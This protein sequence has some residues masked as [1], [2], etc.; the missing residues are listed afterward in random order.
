VSLRVVW[1]SVNPAVRGLQAVAA[2]YADIAENLGS[3]VELKMVIKAA[4]TSVLLTEAEKLQLKLHAAL[5]TEAEKLQLIL[6]AALLT[7]AEKLQL[8]LPAV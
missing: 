8:N 5:L 4:D 7:E 2:V 1:V 6:Q 3:R